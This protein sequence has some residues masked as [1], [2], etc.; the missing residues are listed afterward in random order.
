MKT[1]KKTKSGSPLLWII[2]NSR[3]QLLNI[4]LVVAFYII[5]ALVGVSTALIAKKVIDCAVSGD[6]SGVYFY[7][8]TYAAILISTL[9]LRIVT[10]N[11]YFHIGAKLVMH[12]RLKIFETIINKDY[13]NVSSIHSGELLNRITGDVSIIVDAIVSIMPTLAFMV[14]KLISVLSVLVSI[15]W[16]FTLIFIAAAAVLLFV[17]QLFKKKMKS[18]HKKAQQTEGTVRSYFQEALSGLLMVKVFNSEDEVCK[19]AQKLQTDNYKVQIKRNVISIFA[20]T[21][22]SFIFSA[23]Y[24]YGLLWG[25]LNIASG[26]ITYGTLTAVL[27]LIGQIQSPISQ[28]SGILPRYYGAIA[29]A[30]RLIDLENLPDEPKLN[31]EPENTEEIY[32]N[33]KSIVF[34]NISFRYDRDIVLKNTSLTLNK[35]DFAVIMGISGIGKSTLTKLLMSVYPLDGGRIYFEQTNG[36]EILADKSVRKLYAYVPQGNFLLSGTIR[37]N[38]SF[39]CPGASDSEIMRAA[40]I[41]CAKDFI[42]E[43]PMG[44]DTVIGER[45]LGLSEGQIQR[46]AIAR[47]ILSGSPIIILDE[48][49]SALDEDTEKQLLENIKLLN[50]KTCIIISHKRAAASVCNRRLRIIDGKIIEVEMKAFESDAY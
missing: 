5:L 17:S 16:R 42:E 7:G 25:A 31:K 11:I 35:G 27:S 28:L 13:F 43:L 15:D 44:I 18:L 41:S 45:G 49:T 48:A 8:A 34:D 38:I 30:E 32:E 12:Y 21:S 4:I 50:N 19:R 6:M 46:V 39:A 33:L 14:T 29:S 37:E 2:K 40:E 47:A 22:F 23:G 10:R 9:V 24:L 20:S 36:K 26:I 3:G 1:K